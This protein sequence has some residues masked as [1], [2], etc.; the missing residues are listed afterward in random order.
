[1]VFLFTI[2]GYIYFKTKLWQRQEN[3]KT[4]QEI[5]QILQKEWNRLKK[6]LKF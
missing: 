6:T 1:L 3:Q 4:K 5:E 2:F